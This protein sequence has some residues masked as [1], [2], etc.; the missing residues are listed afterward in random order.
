MLLPQQ[1]EKEV[2][3]IMVIAAAV[4][5]GLNIIFIPAFAQMVLLSQH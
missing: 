5:I 2:S 1:K 4:N 3:I